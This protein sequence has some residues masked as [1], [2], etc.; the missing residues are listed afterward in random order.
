MTASRVTESVLGGAQFVAVMAYLSPAVSCLR[1]VDCVSCGCVWRGASRCA[2]VLRYPAS[3]WLTASRASGVFA[4]FCHVG[5]CRVGLC[6]GG[7][8]CW[9]LRFRSV[10]LYAVSV[11][12]LCFLSFACFSFAGGLLACPTERRLWDGC[13]TT[14]L[15]E[16]W[17]VCCD[18]ELVVSCHPV[19]ALLG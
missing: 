4:F 1:V 8:S 17:R 18:A 11:G 12:A 3:G 2:G 7:F 5:C 6:P 15:C 9:C 16:W 10:L 14:R 19:N 13:W